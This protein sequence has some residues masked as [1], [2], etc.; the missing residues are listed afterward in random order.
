PEITARHVIIQ[1]AGLDADRQDI[2][3]P[4]DEAS[5]IAATANP[6]D[7]TQCT[8]VRANEVTD[9][10]IFNRDF[11]AIA[12]DRR[13]KRVAGQTIFNFLY[14]FEIAFYGKGTTLHIFFEGVK[15]GKIGALQNQPNSHI[16]IPVVI[17]NRTAALPF[18]TEKGRTIEFPG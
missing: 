11:T 10:K 5:R 3:L 17:P 9:P 1:G 16:G 2:P 18:L 15:E 8:R 13:A 12:S 4:H 14:L 7:W 6:F